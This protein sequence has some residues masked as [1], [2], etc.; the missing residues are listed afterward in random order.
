[1]RLV[2]YRKSGYM[3]D[4]L[5]SSGLTRTR[6]GTW[7]S[8]NW[9]R[10]SRRWIRFLSVRVHFLSDA[11]R[12]RTTSYCPITASVVTAAAPYLSATGLDLLFGARWYGCSTK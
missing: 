12:R 11:S 10:A 4:S 3:E 6:H 1:M 2:H 5:I 8:G 7:W 9:P